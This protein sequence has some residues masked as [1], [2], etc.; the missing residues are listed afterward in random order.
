MNRTTF[1]S[2]CMAFLKL[3]YLWGGDDPIKGFDCSGLVQELYAML[4][5]DPS[6]DQTAQGLHDH[7]KARMKEGPRDLGTLVFFGASTSN[8]THVGMMLDEH[9][10]IEAGGG[11]SRTTSSEA[12]AAQNAYVRIRPLTNRKD[13]VAVINPKGLP[14]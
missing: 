10:M 9:S 6:G 1:L 13:L 7:F 12:A 5:L 14:W 11:G 3:P 8:I 4:G 2:A